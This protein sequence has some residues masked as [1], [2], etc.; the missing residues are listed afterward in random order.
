M[1]EQVSHQEPDAFLERDGRDSRVL[2]AQ[3][4]RGPALSRTLR[5]VTRIVLRVERDR[6]SSLGGEL[7]DE[8]RDL[9]HADTRLRRLVHDAML[10]ARCGLPD[11]V[12]E[13]GD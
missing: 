10:P 9:E 12:H 8:V 2:Q 1:L 13:R 11:P 6:N 5:L 4:A 7:A 3:G